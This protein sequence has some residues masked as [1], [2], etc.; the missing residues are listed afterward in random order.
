MYLSTTGWIIHM[1]LTPPQ[2]DR[3]SVNALL[4]REGNGNTAK[5]ACRCFQK[6]VPIETPLRGGEPGGTPTKPTRTQ[7]RQTVKSTPG[8][9]TACT[10]AP[11]VLFSQNEPNHLGSNTTCYITG[12]QQYNRCEVYILYKSKTDRSPRS[13]VASYKKNTHTHTI[14]FGRRLHPRRGTSDIAGDCDWHGG[15]NA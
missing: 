15:Y 3:Q 10:P 9:M 11:R 6:S 5:R 7:N 13:S 12:T 4:W 8:D 14:T 1:Q 2:Q